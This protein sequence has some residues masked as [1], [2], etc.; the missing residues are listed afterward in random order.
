VHVQL[1]PTQ[2]GTSNEQQPIN[3]GISQ[4]LKHYYRRQWLAYIVAGKGSHQNPVFT[5]SLYHTISWI[6]QSW[7]HDL[8][9][10]VIYR[11]FRKSSL[12]DPQIEFITAP[13]SPDL[14]SLY[15]TVTRSNP[16]GRTV[17]TL[18][19]F[20]HPVDEDFEGVL[21]AG[22]FNVEGEPTL[23]DMDDAIGSTLLEQLV[24]P[25]VDAVTGIQTAIRHLAHQPWATAIDI[26]S[27]ERIGKMID[28]T[29]IDERR[30]TYIVEAIRSPV[31]I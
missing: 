17:T 13:K 11:A 16:D 28:R 14:T 5:M 6:T 29:A 7:R 20:T 10:A 8:A 21:N 31:D 12:M 22:G 3:L 19:N 15:E 9:N 25:A 18:E 26:Q 30:Q 24:P 1:L 23:Q 4:I 27:L 2:T